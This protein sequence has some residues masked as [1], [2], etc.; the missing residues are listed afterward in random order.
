MLQQSLH[1]PSYKFIVAKAPGLPDEFYDELLSPYPDVDAV[2]NKT[3]ELL[4]IASAALVTSGTATLE[5]ALF[6]VPQVI[7][8]KGSE[9]SYQVAKRLLKIK[10]IGLVNLIMDKEV[11]KELIQN[12]LTEENLKAE[13]NL[14]LTDEAKIR[15]VKEDY[16][17]LREMLSKDGNASFNAAKI[18][19][20]LAR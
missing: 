11:V 19:Y 1:F 15:Q 3:Y 18:V 9:I 8:Y 12:E 10:Y 2:V 7:C 20:Q 14:I 6:G 13:L 5:T 17:Q 4:S 16:R